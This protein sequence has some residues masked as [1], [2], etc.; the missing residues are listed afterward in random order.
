ML[1]DRLSY[2]RGDK[3]RDISAVFRVLV[4]TV[5]CQTI[6]KVYLLH[7]YCTKSKLQ[8]INLQE[9]CHQYNLHKKQLFFLSPPPPPF[10]FPCSDELVVSRTCPSDLWE[11]V[12]PQSLTQEIPYEVFNMLVPLEPEQKDLFIIRADAALGKDY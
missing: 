4:F 5:S 2:R 6:I 7:I 12:T 1:T 8:Y 10:F 3:F 11:A 9:H